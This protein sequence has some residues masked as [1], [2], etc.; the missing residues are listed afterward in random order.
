VAA[1][2]VACTLS[3]LLSVGIVVFVWV[4]RTSLHNYFT[5]RLIAST[6]RL[7]LRI[8]GLEQDLSVTQGS[9][10]EALRRRKAAHIR[11]ASADE[12]IAAAMDGAT[13]DLRQQ[14][15]AEQKLVSEARASRDVRR[16]ER[17]P[18]V[19]LTLRRLVNGLIG[20]V[21]NLATVVA[22]LVV[23]GAIVGSSIFINYSNTRPHQLTVMVC[24]VVVDNS[25]DTPLGM[26]ETTKG[27]F[28]LDPMVVGST[29]YITSSAATAA[30]SVGQIVNITWH[31]NGFSTHSYITGINQELGTGSC[32]S[33]PPAHPAAS[34]A[35]TTAVY[36]G[37]PGPSAPAAR[38]L[39]LNH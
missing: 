30:F 23:I 12:V 25:G 10:A 39:A 9:F 32:V 8:A 2:I 18:D 4:F 22:V 38:P 6:D 36:S 26:I 14:F 31:G 35:H 27:E 1:V 17:Q 5:A 15:L 29:G 20:A 13:E 37:R 21:G 28:R 33:R 7:R 3:G 16:L 19:G 24:K 11:T 34:S